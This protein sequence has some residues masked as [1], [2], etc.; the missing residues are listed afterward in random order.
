MQVLIAGGAGFI[1]SHTVDLLLSRG[2]SVVVLDNLDERVHRN[3]EWP[4]YLPLNDVRLVRGD[5]RDRRSWI[6]ALQGVDAVIHMAAIQDYRPDYGRYIATNVESYALLYESMIQAGCSIG[7]V[8]VGSSQA[9]YGEGS[10]SCE[11]CGTH[12][13]HP[14]PRSIQQ[15]DEARWDVVCEVCGQ[16]LVCEPAR[17]VDAGARPTSVYGLSKYSGESLA[18]L[19]GRIHA[20][21][22]TVL[23]YSITQ[24][25][26]QSFRNAYSGVLRTYTQRLLHGLPPICFED[27]QQL[28]DYVAVEDV[29]AA[30]ALVLETRTAADVM[31][32]GG[33]QVL[34]AYSF[35]NQAA[36]AL[37]VNLAPEI[38]GVYRVGD[39]RHALSS[40]SRLSALGWSAKRDLRDTMV[41]YAEWATRQ[42]DFEDYS[43]GAIQSMKRN[44]L[45][46]VSRPSR[47]TIAR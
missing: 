3:S 37:G 7:R 47:S 9:I 30:N 45:I 36:E 24:G 8:V 44:G 26:R 29:A 35:A 6:R 4:S 11:T 2:H 18:V 23:R 46:R 38:P 13:F 12:R 33:A 10:Y 40:S 20:V 21:P 39:S 17:E 28:R 43:Q 15:M 1:G 42:P 25:P 41:R 14:K 19:L 32:V 27:G 22:T 16:T 5:V 34:T 31:N